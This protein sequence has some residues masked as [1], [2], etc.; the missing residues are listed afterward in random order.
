MLSA[1]FNVINILDYPNLVY[2]GKISNTNLVISFSTL[3]NII[4]YF[5]FV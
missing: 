3:C 4:Y 5:I 1:V 2:V